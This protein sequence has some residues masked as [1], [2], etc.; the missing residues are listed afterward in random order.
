M[1]GGFAWEVQ[2]EMGRS[3][4]CRSSILR[5]FAYFRFICYPS[6]IMKPPVLALSLLL[7]FGLG[8]AAR[9]V[10]VSAEETD[11][12]AVS[13]SAGKDPRGTALTMEETRRERVASAP[14][15]RSPG[16][17][18][19]TAATIDAILAGSRADVVMTRLGITPQ[20]TEAI[21]TTRAAALDK[22][23]ALETTHSKVIPGANGGYVEIAPFADEAQRWQAGM[24]EELRKTFPDD[25]AVL[26]ARMIA[27]EHNDQN[28][29]AYR[30][31]LHSE[32]APDD[33]KRILLEEKLFDANGQ[34]IDSDFEIVSERSRN[35]WGHLLE[36]D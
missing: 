11:A 19:F 16:T 21:K 31:Q 17:Y 30:R 24:E 6:P 36:F 7:A 34:V 26:L 28:A 3:K 2:R 23:K 8:V 4:E 14:Q 10:M 33:P 15:E 32:P 20:E 9:H 12:A 25:R 18:Q 27:N 22:L 1:L 5:P 35:R 29:S 13:S